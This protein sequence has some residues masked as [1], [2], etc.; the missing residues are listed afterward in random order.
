MRQTVLN[1]T[2]FTLIELLVVVAII[3]VLVAVLLPAIAQVREKARRMKCMTNQKQ[4]GVALFMYSG[5]YHGMGPYNRRESNSSWPS[6]WQWLYHDQWWT[7]TQEVQFGLLRP[8]VG[9]RDGWG[10]PLVMQCPEGIWFAYGTDHG[11]CTSYMINPAVGSNADYKGKLENLPS[12]STAVVDV[13]SWW[14]PYPYPT[15]LTGGGNHESL[16]M[17]VLKVDG[18]VVW[19]LSED[20]YWK[21]G[22]WSWG[23]LDRF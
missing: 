10:C 12:D 5:D 4:I 8:Y 9:F 23:Y 18:H 13:I 22:A 21:C 11:E 16:G 2:S 15:S 3:A 20:T 6:P 7:V 19:V 17:Y 14:A 1:K